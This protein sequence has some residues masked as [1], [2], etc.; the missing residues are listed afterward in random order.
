MIGVEIRLDLWY[1]S[2]IDQGLVPSQPVSQ[3]QLTAEGSVKDWQPIVILGA[4][5]V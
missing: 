3:S 5:L 1:H 4:V 2:S